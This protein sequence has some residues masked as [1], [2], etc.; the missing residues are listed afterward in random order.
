MDLFSLGWTADRQAEFDQTNMSG[1]AARVC[2][3]HRGA[4]DLWS[5]RG[6]TRASI[7]GA[8]HHEGVRPVVGDWV[9]AQDAGD[10]SA[11]VAALLERRSALARKAAG[12]ASVEQLVAANLDT[13]FVVTALDGDLNPRRLERYVTAVWDG[14]ASP[15]VLVNKIDLVADPEPALAEAAASAAGA[16][17]IGLSAVHEQGLDALAPHLGLGATVALVGSSG[18]G[19]STIVNALTNA[20][21]ATQ[22][23]GVDAKGQHTTTSRQMYRLAAGAVLVD[24][25]GMR[26]LALLDAG[27]GLERAFGDVEG[28]AQGCRFR[29]C[30]HVDEPGCAVLA[31]IDEG[32]LPAER[33]VSYQKLEREVARQAR[34]LDG[35]A[36]A[37]ERKRQRA[38]SRMCRRRTQAKQR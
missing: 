36:Q 25:P 18:V 35:R 6:T 31:A 29:D 22:G 23:L 21:V 11:R 7:A 13:V 10:G 9:I 16:E 2:A 37:E 8:L 32:D 20:G 17:V 3:E 4:V 5:E 34:L 12:K 1:W 14:G 19:K 26:E 33:L 30:G 28:F 15:V 27:E 24:T 38:F